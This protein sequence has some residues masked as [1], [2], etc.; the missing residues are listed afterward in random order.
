MAIVMCGPNCSTEQKNGGHGCGD[1]QVS[2][3]GMVL[4]TWEVNGSSD[5]DFYALVWDGANGTKAIEYAS[6]RGWTYHNSARV[7]ASAVVQRQARES[8]RERIRTACIQQ[9][10]AMARMV[11]KGCSVRSTTTRGANVGVEGIITWEGVDRYKSTR[12]ATV[13]RFGV[14]VEGEDKLRYFSEDQIERTRPDVIDVDDVIRLADH[15]VE[16]AN[17]RSLARFIG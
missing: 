7:D 8:H 16:T 9:A 1:P 6:T 12:Y 14:K 5:S 17:F 15:Y 3:E 2:Y 10:H 13:R 4:D 11:R